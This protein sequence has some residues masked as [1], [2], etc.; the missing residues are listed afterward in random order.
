MR[1][2]CPQPGCRTFEV[3]KGP[4]PKGFL[5]AL[6]ATIQTDQRGFARKA[7]VPA[8]VGPETGFGEASV[9]RFEKAS[10]YMS[11]LPSRSA[12]CLSSQNH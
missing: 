3:S 4:A 6:E 5:Q 12:P 10:G 2:C 11:A 1:P 9:A 8:R 7:G